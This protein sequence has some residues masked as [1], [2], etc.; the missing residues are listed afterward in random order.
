MKNCKIKRV[1][2]PYVDVTEFTFTHA[3]QL[4]LILKNQ[5]LGLPD[6]PITGV[7]YISNGFI[8]YC[9]TNSL[10]NKYDYIKLTP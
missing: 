10:I 2:V 4:V 5:P 3:K 9:S 6:F 7:F 8:K 1:L